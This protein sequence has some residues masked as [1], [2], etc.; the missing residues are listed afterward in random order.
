MDSQNLEQHILFS[1]VLPEKVGVLFGSSALGS[2]YPYGNPPVNAF[3]F[4]NFKIEALDTFQNAS[5]HVESVGR[6]IQF[7]YIMGFL[8]NY[9]GILTVMG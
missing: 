6:D 8:H 5:Y 2:P 4:I 7:M 1:R 3:I 9:W